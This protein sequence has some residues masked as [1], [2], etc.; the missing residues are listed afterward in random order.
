MGASEQ[1]AGVS[2]DTEGLGR[3]AEAAADHRGEAADC[4]RDAGG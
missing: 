1:V 3:T 4:G 2:K